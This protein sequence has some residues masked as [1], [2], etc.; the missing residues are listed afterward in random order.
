MSLCFC[1]SL[2]HG[3]SRSILYFCDSEYSIRPPQVFLSH[4]IASLM[5]APSFSD[6]LPSGTSNGA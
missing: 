2:S 3:L 4:F 5:M 6:R 1:G